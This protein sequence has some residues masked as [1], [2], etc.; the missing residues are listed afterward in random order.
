MLIGISTYSRVAL[1]LPSVSNISTTGEYAVPV[2]ILYG[3]YILIRHKNCTYQVCDSM[4]SSPLP[5]I[6]YTLLSDFF[7]TIVNLFL[8]DYIISPS[9]FNG[10]VQNNSAE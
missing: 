2:A 1:S 3:L 4:Y 5:R 8:S 9:S 10:N 7:V 6:V